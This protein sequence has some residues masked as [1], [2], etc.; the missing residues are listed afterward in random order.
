MK[1][2]LMIVLSVL[3]VPTACNSKKEKT[4]DQW[5]E[6]EL[7][8]WF[9]AGEWKRGWE[10]TPDESIDQR[11]FA[12]QYNLNP[13]RWE[14]AFQF[15]S[16]QDLSKLE[17]GRHELEGPDLFVNVDEYISRNE[18]DVLFEAHKKY[19]DIQVLVS[20]EE[21]IGVLPLESTTLAVPYN[22][23]KDIAF[24]SA[25]ADNYRVATPGRF[26]MFFPDDAHRPTVKTTENS[27][28]RKVVVKVR[29][30]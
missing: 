29:I 26:F 28:V 5:S 18:E 12:I 25:D 10:A 6:G 3:I 16:E 9:N 23:E 1:T 7:T 11:E 21:K 17:L 2:K 22:E 13:Q 27:Q 15:L 8:E 30:Q 4:P 20:G 19:A 14:K 24:F